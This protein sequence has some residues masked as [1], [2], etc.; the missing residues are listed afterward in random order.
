MSSLKSCHISQ[1]SAS[2]KRRAIPKKEREASSD[3]RERRNSLTTLSSEAAGQ[4]D[5]LALD[6]DTLGVDGAEI[7]VLEERDEVSLNGLL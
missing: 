7:G 5:V 4:L 3:C 1:G 2:E 6:G